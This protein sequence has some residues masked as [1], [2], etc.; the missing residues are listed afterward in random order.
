MNQRKATKKRIL[1]VSSLLILIT[2]SFVSS[3]QQDDFLDEKKDLT[4]IR[5][6]PM[7][8]VE[9][10]FGDEK[11]ESSSARLLKNKFSKNLITHKTINGKEIGQLETAFGKVN[12][13]KSVELKDSLNNISTSFEIKEEV[14]NPNVYLN[15]IVD[16]NEV[17]WLYKIERIQQ[18]LRGFPVNTEMVSRYMMSS[19]LNS[20]TPCDSIFY[21]DV[22]LLP[23]LLGGG[24]GGLGTG[25]TTDLPATGIINPGNG[26]GSNFGFFDNI[27]GNSGGNGDGGS[28]ASG[29]S[30]TFLTDMLDTIG[31]GLVDAWSWVKD[32]IGDLFGGG[33]CSCQRRL[34]IVEVAPDS[35]CG[36]GGL[37][38]IIIPDTLSTFYDSLSPE[39]QDWWDTHP[40]ENVLITQYLWQNGFNSQA[41]AFAFWAID[42]LD[43]N[44]DTTWEQFENWFMGEPQ[45]QDYFYDASFWNN[46][47]NLNFQQQ[48]LPSYD[49]FLNGFPQ[50]GNGGFL[51][52]ADNIYPLVGG[53]VLLVRQTYPGN[54]TKNVCALKVSIALNNSGVIIPNIENQTIEGGGDYAGKY[55]FLNVRAL[56][57]W[58][59]VTFGTSTP[60]DGFPYNENHVSFTGEQGGVNG[61]NYPNLVSGLKGIY[62]LVMPVG[63]SLSGHADLIYN[64]ICPSGCNFQLSVEHIDI[65]ILE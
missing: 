19:D 22:S 60:N 31:G 5:H 50:N 35:P 63:S 30:L 24:P 46:P 43:N 25:S 20:A 56:N 4:V 3:C 48:D 8:N 61:Q 18:P 1:L 29:I 65:W 62:M 34:M 21:P 41:Q 36:E 26:E 17:V 10:S 14:K 15:L 59:R 55:F 2:I 57:D 27:P 12:L 39:Q 64:N 6:K 49:D 23:N 7:P 52:G 42:F 13:N 33:S 58:M 44:P 16:K 51:H 47:N 38:P 53:D 54:Q 11:T 9:I 37:V 28:D 32:G 45:G 40:D